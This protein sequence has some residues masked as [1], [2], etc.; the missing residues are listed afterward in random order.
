MTGEEQVFQV[1][2]G[3]IV[4]LL[5]HNLYSGPKVFVRELLQNGVDAI[6][7]RHS[8]RPEER[9]EGRIRFI[10]DSD[11]LLVIDNGKGLTT[12]EAAE[13]LSAIGASSKRDQFGLGR[14]DY[15]GQ[16][17]IGML[18]CFMV[19]PLINVWS[20]SIEQPDV[21]ANWQGRSEGTWQ[22]RAAAHAP[23]ELVGPGTLVELRPHP[24]ER[25]FDYRHLAQLVRH[26]G[27][28]LPV[29]VTIERPGSEPE[30]LTEVVRPWEQADP[31]WCAG[32]FGFDPFAA[33]PLNVPVAGL[34][35]MA[36]VLST[37]AFPGQITRH[38]VYVRSMLVNDRASDIVPDWAYFVRAVVDS[39]YLRPTASREAL[40]D[41][42]LLS[43]TRD[44]IGQAIR[45]WLSDLAR[46]RPD[47]FREFVHLHLHGLKALA[48]SDRP[49][50]DLVSEFVPYRTS[51]GMMSLR[52]ILDAHHELLFTPSDDQFR[53][54][55][56]VAAAN[57]L[58]IV[59]G[60][61]AFDEEI[62][63]ALHQ[64]HPEWQI[65]PVS[66]GEILESLKPADPGTSQM[67]RPLVEAA[68]AALAVQDLDVAVR[69]FSPATLPMVYLPEPDMAGQIIA[70][71]AD[72]LAT[73][74][75]S[76]YS[77]LIGMMGTGLAPVAK[78]LFIL[79]ST[80]EVIHQ[81][82]GA[83]DPTLVE[84]AIRGLY[85]QA[86]MAG[87]HHIDPQVRAWSTRI[88]SSLIAHS[89]NRSGH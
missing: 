19:S 20:R 15:I 37:K 7:A 70:R 56:P 42:D 23:A 14:M 39:Q 8:L 43:E 45:D 60:G 11:R 65:R 6:T 63:T 68:Y 84:A 78:P 86:L 30:L 51:L 40:F 36:Y 4:E 24:G 1:D 48:L 27:S 71:Q 44:A 32:E 41:D 64:I 61:F 53:A 29:R 73:Q 52:S 77:G 81:L 17:G 34:R 58:C 74:T 67:L 87:N 80:C 12:S 85:V 9:V 88:F 50:L 31:V 76:V 82:A 57:G 89:M 3:G 79:N 38:K 26:Y 49:T 83:D 28:Y 72:D 59:N 13:L 55:E 46:T 16:F 35:G 47:Q 66:P 25:G 5:S 22:I 69:S 18:S 10:V 2:L 21:V 75:G 33:I 54:L 62:F